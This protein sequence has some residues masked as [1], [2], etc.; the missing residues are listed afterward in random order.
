MHFLPLLLLAVT[1]LDPTTPAE[2]AHLLNTPTESLSKGIAQG[3]PLQEA[4]ALLSLRC[5]VKIEIDTVEFQKTGVK[6]IGEEKVQLAPMSGIPLE[7]GLQFVLDSL[8]GNVTFK[9]KDTR[10]IIIP[11]TRI[12]K[13]QSSTS[14]FVAQLRKQTEEYKEGMEE[15]AF[16]EALEL[17]RG[18][19]ELSLWVRGKGFPMA[20]EELKNKK[21]KLPKIAK[22]TFG[23]ILKRLLS[24]V[25]ATYIVRNEYILIV[26]AKGKEK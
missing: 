16:L 10:I 15:M 11:G 4:L 20:W 13:D 2:L 25:G 19:C 21:V 6:N 18:R 22:A 8:P 7:L 1:A 23:D 12:F 5:K 9:T 14:R 24:Q 17:L 3:T 26:A